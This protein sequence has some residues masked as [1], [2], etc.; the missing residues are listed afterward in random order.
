M[1]DA[2]RCSLA[3]PVS[4]A[5]I[6]LVDDVITTGSSLEAAASVLKQAGAKRVDAIVF[7]QKQE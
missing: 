2:F 5:H 7:A 6:I 3:V 1:T 4:G